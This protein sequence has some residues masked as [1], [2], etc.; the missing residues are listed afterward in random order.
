MLKIFNYFLTMY[1][2]LVVRKTLHLACKHDE[3]HEDIFRACICEH[4]KCY[5]RVLICSLRFVNVS[6]LYQLVFRVPF[7][8]A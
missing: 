2:L 8:T 4:I 3:V 7:D 6:S 1:T 5:V